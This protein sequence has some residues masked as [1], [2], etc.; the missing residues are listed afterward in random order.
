HPVSPWGM[1][2]KGHKTRKKGKASDR[3]IIRRRNVKK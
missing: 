2:T 3:Y 1:P